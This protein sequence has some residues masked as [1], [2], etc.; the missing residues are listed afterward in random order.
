MP[1]PGNYV[2]P[3][4]KAFLKACIDPSSSPDIELPSYHI[5]PHLPCG[6]CH[7]IVAPP[8]GGKTF[9]ALE[10]C[11]SMATGDP[12]LGRHPVDAGGLW[13]FIAGEG[14]AQTRLRWQMMQRKRGVQLPPNSLLIYP[15]PVNFTEEAEVDTLIAAAKLCGAK[16]LIVDTASRCGA[17]AEDSNDMP[18]FVAGLTRAA[19]DASL[20]VVILHHTPLV[21]AK[22]ARGHT[23]LPAAIDTQWFMETEGPPGKDR[24]YAL[25]VSFSRWSG[26][27]DE[28]IGKFQLDSVLA[29]INSD[30]RKCE[31]G[32]PRALTDEQIAE[33]AAKNRLTKSEKEVLAA[34]EAALDKAADAMFDTPTAFL[35]RGSTQ[36]WRDH[37]FQSQRSTKP[38]GNFQSFDKAWRRGQAALVAKGRVAEG[39][40]GWWAIT[41]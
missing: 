1:E 32:V 35:N 34:L 14:E 26:S 10:L 24:V 17:G 41:R 38:D 40:S 7:L 23:A 11:W 33:H 28:A 6:G 9:V 29:G 18:A 21:D 25:H 30:G 19:N 3:K 15:R 22:R 2:N 8:K 27:S 13:L 5:Y 37:Y 36:A 20:T 12:F 4:V 39:P 31:V 16:G